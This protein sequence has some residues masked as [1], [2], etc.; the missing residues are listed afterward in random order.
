[1]GSTGPTHMTRSSRFWE[2]TGAKWTVLRMQGINRC[3]GTVAFAPDGKQLYLPGQVGW[4]CASATTPNDM[5]TIVEDAATGNRNGEI[6]YHTPNNVFGSAFT[7]SPDATRLYATG[8]INPSDPN[9]DLATI[10]FQAD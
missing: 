10:A 9:Y 4:P 1:M 8:V 2:S 5:F 3:V 6:R 7:L